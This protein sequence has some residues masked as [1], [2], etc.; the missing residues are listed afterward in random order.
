MCDILE[1]IHKKLLYSHLVCHVY[2]DSRR[3]RPSSISAH[4]ELG[5]RRS[6]PT[7]LVVKVVF[8]LV[9]IYSNQHGARSGT[10]K[11]ASTNNPLMGRDQHIFMIPTSISAQSISAHW[12]FGVSNYFNV[13]RLEYLGRDRPGPKSTGRDRRSPFINTVYSIYY[14]YYYYWSEIQI[15]LW[16]EITYT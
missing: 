3:Y 12:Q 7:Y 15:L 10:Y 1:I 9:N 8:P 13:N 4:V 6:W 11:H 5:P 2:K 14:Y 16:T